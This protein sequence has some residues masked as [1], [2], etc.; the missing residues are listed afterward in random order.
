M[1]LKSTFRLLLT[2]FICVGVF[3]SCATKKESSASRGPQGFCL[4]GGTSVRLASGKDIFIEQLKVGD[5]VLAFDRVKKIFRPAKVLRVAQ[6]EHAGFVKLNF[7]SGEG[8]SGNSTS[9][10]TI[11]SDHPIWVKRKGWCSLEPEIT[12]RVLSMNNVQKL[13]AGDTCYSINAKKML[14]EIKLLSIEKVSGVVKAY[15][16]VQLSSEQ[17]CFLAGTILVGTEAV[18]IEESGE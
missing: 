18:Q 5:T 3:Y 2:L 10:L 16:I 17:D 1:S 7:P 14:S 4:A 8:T 9:S 13:N 6:T 15:T 11:T 12:K